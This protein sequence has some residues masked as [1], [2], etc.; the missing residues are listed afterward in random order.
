MRPRDW[1]GVAVRVL[2]LWFFTEAA[3][4]LYWVIL[5]TDFGL[6]NPEI[7]VKQEGMHA[8]FYCLLALILLFLADPIVWLVYG[9]PPKVT[10]QISREDGATGD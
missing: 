4:R 1:F 9:L 2:G 10:A 3:E 6:G 8:A 5:K 7:T